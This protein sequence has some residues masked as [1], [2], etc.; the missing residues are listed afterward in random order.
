VGEF[1]ALLFCMLFLLFLLWIFFVDKS[2]IE[3]FPVPEKSYPK[4]TLVIYDKKRHY[5][6]LD[7]TDNWV[8]SNYYIVP[9]HLHQPNQRGSIYEGVIEVAPNKIICAKEFRK[10]KISKLLTKK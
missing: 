3:S 6:V 10:H 2:G 7:C 1:V 5:V 4:G 9:E 8:E